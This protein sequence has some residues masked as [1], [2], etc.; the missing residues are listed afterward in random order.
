METLTADRQSTAPNV[1]KVNR[2]RERLFYTGMRGSRS[3]RG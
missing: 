3:R 2:R 1:L